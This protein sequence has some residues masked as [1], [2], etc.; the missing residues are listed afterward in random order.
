MLTPF[1][2]CRYV[3][4]SRTAESS[5]GTGCSVGGGAGNVQSGGMKEVFSLLAIVVYVS[6][7]CRDAGCTT[8]INPGQQSKSGF[9]LV[10]D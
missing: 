6:E 4:G 10:V 9:Q 7:I 5:T 8:H 3:A 1:H 2:P